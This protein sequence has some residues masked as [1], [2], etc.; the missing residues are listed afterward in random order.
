LAQQLQK[1]ANIPLNAFNKAVNS[2]ETRKHIKRVKSVK[3]FPPSETELKRGQKQKLKIILMLYDLE[4]AEDLTGGPWYIENEGLDSVFV[5][6]LLQVVLRV[7]DKRSFPSAKKI[8]RPDGTEVIINRFYQPTYRGYATA[9]DVYD[10]IIAAN[11]LQ[12][13]VKESFGVS[14]VH[15]LLEVAC[16]TK[17][18]QK[19]TDG[20]TYRS[21]L[22]DEEVVEP[23]ELDVLFNYEGLSED[24]NSVMLQKGYT[25]APCGRCPVFRECGDPGEEVSAATCRYWDEWTSQIRPDDF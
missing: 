18:I 21:L 12:D 19:R 14:Q 20:V 13:D 24:L 17:Q 11:I 10:S 2:L 3:V 4:P 15:Q 8:A 6:D 25:E 7:V 22:S 9:Q 1:A 16:V 5:D 23:D